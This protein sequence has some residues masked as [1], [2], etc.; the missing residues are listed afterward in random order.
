[1][2]SNVLP[3]GFKLDEYIVE[4]VLGEG[5]FGISYKAQDP[6]L[7]T[8]VVI[9][10]YFPQSLARRSDSMVIVPA[11]GEA[12][13]HFE[14]G[15]QQ[16]LNEVRSLAK[17][18]HNH[19][20]RVTRFMEM[21]GTAYMVMEFEAGQS[22]QDFLD[23]NPKPDERTLMQV[24]IPIL[25]GLQAVHQA[26]LLHLDIKPENI[27]LRQDMTPLLIDF[28]SAKH[29][30]Q[31]SD[32]NGMV[33]LSPSFAAPE[34]FP[35]RGKLGPWTD[36]Y[37]I[38]ASLYRCVAG[39]EPGT[40]TMRT[41]LVKQGASDPLE[42]LASDESSGFSAYLR[43]C[44][45]W[46]MHME[47]ARRPLTAMALQDALMGKGI[48]GKK[49]EPK[50]RPEPPPRPAAVPAAAQSGMASWKVVE[51]TV[52]LPEEPEAPREPMVS[53]ALLKRLAI[54]LVL[55]AAIGGGVFLF[56][57]N[58]GLVKQVARSL[59]DAGKVVDSAKQAVTGQGS[60]DVRYVGGVD[61][62]QPEQPRR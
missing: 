1:M 2:A 52:P 57:S 29:V 55:L 13:K 32:P 28:G 22:L 49:P 19:I 40:E 7:G 10:E 26:G 24:F 25:N 23:R 20:V 27:F 5:G 54:V 9:K 15:R 47:S 16:F 48:D 43:Q 31:Q 62:P 33:A 30:A 53:G 12:S 41:E 38:G 4:S 46:T 37:S 42:P 61:P 39:S 18:R 8:S 36:L 6:K 11:P 59:P 44:I 50:R 58:P 35:P 3:R 17:F 45:D 56:S 34:Q 14:W 51:S 21:L 60:G